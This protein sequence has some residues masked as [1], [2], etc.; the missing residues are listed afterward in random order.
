[1]MMKSRTKRKGRRQNRRKRRRT[2][3]KE[4]VMMK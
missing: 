3:W 1:M 4:G 2:N